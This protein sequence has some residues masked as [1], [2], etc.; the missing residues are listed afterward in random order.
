MVIHRILH[1]QDIEIELTAEEMIDAY[2]EQQYIFDCEDVKQYIDA[3]YQESDIK[4]VLLSKTIEIATDT[5]KWINKTGVPWF[6]ACAHAIDWQEHVEKEK[7]KNE[8]GQP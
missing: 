1:G 8:K 5:R 4:D 6:M 3:H 7:E 2:F